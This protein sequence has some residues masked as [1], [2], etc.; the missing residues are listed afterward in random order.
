MPDDGSTTEQLVEE[1]MARIAGSW[2]WTGTRWETVEQI[3][4]KRIADNI[5][6]LSPILGERD[7]FCLLVCSAQVRQEREWQSK[8][9]PRQDS[10]PAVP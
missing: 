7:E 9:Y 10:P 5:L 2:M 6:A 1:S 4:R 8:P 3:I